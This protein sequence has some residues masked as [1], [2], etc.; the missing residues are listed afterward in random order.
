MPIEGTPRDLIER[1]RADE[2]DIA[3]VRMPVAKSDG[4]VIEPLL[5]EPMV[6]ALPNGHTLAQT[7][8]GVDKPISLNALSEEFYFLRTPKW[9]EDVDERGDQHGMPQRWLQPSHRPWS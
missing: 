4:I 7:K 3:F 9:L 2:I 1:I 5:E 6:V 8:N